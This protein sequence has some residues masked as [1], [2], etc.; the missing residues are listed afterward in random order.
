M[1]LAHGEIMD[2]IVGGFYNKS[3][4][5]L[6]STNRRLLFIDKGLIYGLKVE[7]FPLDKISSISYE[8]GIITG[9]IRIYTSGNTTEIDYVEKNSAKIFAEFVRDKLSSPKQPDV[10]TPQQ[11]MLD[12]LEKLAKL[13]DSGIITDDEFSEQKRKILEKL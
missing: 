6:V 7:D 3:K 12:Q 10:H 9:K 11:S 2:N 4:G 1:I 13:R 8:T 5:I